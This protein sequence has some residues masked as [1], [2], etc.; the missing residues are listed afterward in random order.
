MKKGLLVFIFIT[1]LMLSACTDKKTQNIAPVGDNP[2]AYLQDPETRHHIIIDTAFDTTSQQW[3]IL[4]AVSDFDNEETQP[5]SVYFSEYA[6]LEI[7]LFNAEGEFVSKIKTDLAPYTTSEIEPILPMPCTFQNNILSF[8]SNGYPITYTF[9]NI[10]QNTYK[11]VEQVLDV[12][13][14][15]EYYVFYSENWNDTLPS[16]QRMFTFQLFKQDTLVSSVEV[17][18]A[19]QNFTTRNSD[20]L[21]YSFAFDASTQKAIASTGIVSYVVDFETGTWHEERTYAEADLEELL[22]TSPD[23]EVEIY[24]AN[25]GSAGDGFWHD[26][27]ARDVK[28][29]EVTF[30]CVRYGHGLILFG[31]EGHIVVNQIGSIEIYDYHTGETVDEDF[32]GFDEKD[33]FINGIAYD[34]TEQLYVMCYF[35]NKHEMFSEEEA[36]FTIG[37]FTANGTLLQETIVD[38]TEQVYPYRNNAIV[39]YTL[40]LHDDG[41]V[42]VSNQGNVFGTATYK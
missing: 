16:G 15:G 4:Y 35:S 18:S 21:Q 11:N 7:Q 38:C 20:S 34:E 5:W 10:A 29:G 8:C 41:T 39:Q 24:A 19:D 14:D 17:M 27:V 36:V 33:F 31:Q 9:Y 1:A 22:L 28:T 23:G 26:L 3:A 13:M 6:H 40:T 30:V 12:A 2:A 42:T 37:T 32:A 25:R